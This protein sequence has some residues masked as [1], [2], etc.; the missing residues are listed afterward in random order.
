MSLKEHI[1]LAMEF[2]GS[3]FGLPLNEESI[4]F[5]EISLNIYRKWLGLS[6]SETLKIQVPSN[7]N[8]C[9][10]TCYQKI[11]KHISLIFEKRLIPSK[12]SFYCVLES[13][14][15]RYY[16]LCK[17]VIR[18]YHLISIELNS[19]MSEETWEVLLNVILGITDMLVCE[20]S[21]INDELLSY[22]FETLIEIWLYSGL[23]KVDLLNCLSMLSSEWILQKSLFLDK[24]FAVIKGLTR[25]LL[26]IL[27]NKP[28]QYSIFFG[29]QPLTQSELSTSKSEEAIIKDANLYVYVAFEQKTAVFNIPDEQV[30]Y[31]WFRFLFLLEPRLG[32][33]FPSGI[34]TTRKSLPCIP[35]KYRHYIKIMSFIIK[36]FSNVGR[37]SDL[38]K[39]EKIYIEQNEFEMLIKL[40]IVPRFVQSP[41]YSA[42]F[43]EL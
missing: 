31:F 27:F 37:I 6:I 43:N 33:Q 41:S 42:E 21:D 26:N 19:K 15:E 12:H 40:K 14:I 23:Q 25:R 7:F 22:L 4:Q 2:I 32:S 29:K 34:Q 3:C 36:E 30:L 13:L 1:K 8:D 28:C 17:G 24:W 35:E 39:K 16:N 5:I 18:T 9:C 10:Q 11:I 38:K 20:N